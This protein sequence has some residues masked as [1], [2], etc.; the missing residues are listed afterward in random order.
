MKDLGVVHDS[1]LVFDNHINNIISSALKALG[2]IMR[3]STHFTQAKTLKVL[4]CSYVRS[5]LE[6]ASQIWNPCYNTYSDRIER[7]QQKF[8]KHLCFKLKCPYSSTNYI[9][10]CK[11]HHLV[12]LKQRREIADIIYLLNITNGVTDCPELLRKLNFNTPTRSK[13]H[14]PPI[15]ISSASSNYR[16]NSFLNRASRNLNKL[17]EEIDIDIFNSKIPSVRRNL[18]ER[19]FK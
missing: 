5:K 11:R 15:S 7:I 9:S 12:P 8:I 3:S 16:Q 19:Y 6:Y 4:Y 18:V 2:F 10:I 17:T 1:K 13:R 14:H